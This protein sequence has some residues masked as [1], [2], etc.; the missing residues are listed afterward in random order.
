[1]IAKLYKTSLFFFPMI[2]TIKADLFTINADAY[3][4][5]CNVQG[6]MGSGIAREFKDR[7]PAMFKEYRSYCQSGTFHVG[8]IHFYRDNAQPRPAIIYL[9]TQFDVDTGADLTYVRETFLKIR[10]NYQTWGIKSLAMPMV[11]T[12]RG[13]LNWNQVLPVLKEVFEHS[14]LEVIVASL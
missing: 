3:A 8:D 6:V 12:G 7:Y 9:A 10:E 14:D 4:H 2:K 11:A 5:G 1:M 13:K